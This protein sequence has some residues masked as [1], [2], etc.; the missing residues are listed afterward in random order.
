MSIIIFFGMALGIFLVGVIY[1]S[2]TVRH[3]WRL[4]HP[5]P[6]PKSHP[7]NKNQDEKKS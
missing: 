5:L 3:H 4:S 1:V 7:E 2:L 6:L